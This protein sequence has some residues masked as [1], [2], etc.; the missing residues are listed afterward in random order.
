M[1]VAAIA[2]KPSPRYRF[3]LFDCLALTTFAAMLA[4][5]VAWLARLR[6]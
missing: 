4:G 5:L 3:S 2:L 6:G 1:G